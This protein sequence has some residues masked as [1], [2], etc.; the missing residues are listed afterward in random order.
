MPEQ[1]YQIDLTRT[2]NSPVT[3]GIHA[4]KI[5]S[6]EEAEGP[7]GPYWKFN[8]TCLTPGE[9]G[10]NVFTIV[11]LSP[12]A[13]WRLEIFLDAVGAPSSGSATM[14]KFIGRQ[15]RAKVTHEMYEGRVQARLADMFPMTG[16]KAA[17]VTPAVAIKR[18]E[19]S[20]VEPTFMP[21]DVVDDADEEPA[22]F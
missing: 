2:A 1:T 10:K 4:F 14:D 16:G 8:C 20:P 6:G 3:E 5:V 21:E 22:P 17:P 9:E 18:A 7:K 11:S 12:Q 13:R 19:T 15:F